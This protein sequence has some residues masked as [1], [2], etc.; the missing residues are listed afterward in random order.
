[1]TQALSPKI[2]KYLAI[3]ALSMREKSLHT[4]NIVGSA[5]VILLRIWIFYALYTAAFVSQNIA[6]MQHQ[7]VQMIVWTLMFSQSFQMAAKPQMMTEIEE[8]IRSGQIAN[9][10]SKPYSYLLFNFFLFT[11][12]LLPRLFLNVLTGL[13]ACLILLGPITITLSGLASGLLTLILGIILHFCISMMICLSAFWIET[14]RPLYWIYS[15]AQLVLGGLI[16]PLTLLPGM[17]KT[18]SELLPFSQM[19]YTPATLLIYFRSDTFSH[20]LLIQ[21]AWIVVTIL[22]LLLL[23]SKGVRHVAQNGG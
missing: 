9:T 11:G 7:T 20:V 15:K 1:M 10:I 12:R 22:L 14:T 13:V 2:Q 23:F 19:F 16:V 6:S 5:L 8:T 17:V 3:L 4:A 18:V 21:L